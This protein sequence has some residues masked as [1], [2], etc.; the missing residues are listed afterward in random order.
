MSE[1]GAGAR[2]ERASKTKNNLKLNNCAIRCIN[3]TP[4]KSFLELRWSLTFVVVLMFVLLKDVKLPCNS[5]P[6]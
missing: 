5:A 6:S 4:Q 2:S 3:T 1:L